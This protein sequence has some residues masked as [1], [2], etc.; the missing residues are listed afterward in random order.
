MTPREQ[1][2]EKQRCRLELLE[3]RCPCG[4]RSWPCECRRWGCHFY[5]GEAEGLVA[6]PV[7]FDEGE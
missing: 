2:Q 4:E 6:E 1:A 5:N 7:F 3:A